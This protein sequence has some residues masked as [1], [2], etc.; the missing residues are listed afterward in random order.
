TSFRF[1][2]PDEFDYKAGQYMIVTIKVDDKELMHPFSFSSSPT[3]QDFIEFTKKLTASEYSTRLRAMKPGDWARIDGPYGNFTCECEYGR[4]VFLAGGIGITPF[5]SI[6]KYC[7]DYKLATNMVLFYGCRNEKEIAFKQQLDE[8]Q[9]N[10][11]NVRVIYVLNEASPSWTGKV[12]F[13]NAD[14][15]RQEVPDFQDRVF[16]ACGPPVMVSA[17]QKLIIALGLPAE[18][19]KTESLVGHT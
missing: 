15:I 8:I 2:R 18:Q 10:N 16:Y 14:L 11:P 19:L 1:P 3:D 4:I 13:L 17:M 12:G 7:T 6:M 5:F 9:A